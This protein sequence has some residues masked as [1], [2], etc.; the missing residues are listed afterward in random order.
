[1]FTAEL[2]KYLATFNK[3]TKALPESYL[4]NNLFSSFLDLRF[5]FLNNE[6]GAR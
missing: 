4:L 1:M 5:K 6:F 2:I 3:E